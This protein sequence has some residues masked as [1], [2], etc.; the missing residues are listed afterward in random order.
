M[1]QCDC[2]GWKE[3]N[4]K[5]IGIYVIAKIHGVIYDGPVGDYCMWCGKKLKN[6]NLKEDING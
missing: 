3:G 4:Q 1:K 6:V 2:K 5:V